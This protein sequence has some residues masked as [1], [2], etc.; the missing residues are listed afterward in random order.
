MKVVALV[1]EAL[2]AKQGGPA[3]TDSLGS[4]TEEQDNYKNW[5][6]VIQ[7][8]GREIFLQ[9]ACPAVSEPSKSIPATPPR[10]PPVLMPRTDLLL[11]IVAFCREEGPGIGL[12][13]LK[14][15]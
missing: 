15:G 4:E 9:L 2:A 8:F 10:G 7:V 13:G 5:Q 14:M 11:P 3:G 6:P 12:G 1:R